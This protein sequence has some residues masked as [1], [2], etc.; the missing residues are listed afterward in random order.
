MESESVT[1][2]DLELQKKLEK[3]PLVSLASDS[4]VAGTRSGENDKNTVNPLLHKLF[5]LYT[6][7]GCLCLIFFST[8]LY[9]DFV[10][11]TKLDVRFDSAA[12][13]SLNDT[14]GPNLRSEE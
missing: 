11:T 4:P 14:I 1:L 10:H 12:F 8:A 5:I 13:T 7:A 3:S 2:H 6:I 9:N